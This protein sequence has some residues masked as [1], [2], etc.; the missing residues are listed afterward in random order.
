MSTEIVE[1]IPQRDGGVLLEVPSGE[2]IVRGLAMPHS[3]RRPRGRLWLLESGTGSF[4]FV[5]RAAGR[6]ESVVTLPGFTRGLAFR[7]NLAFVGLLQ[8][9][10][11]ANF[12][13]VPI[14]EHALASGPA[15]SGPDAGIVWHLTLQLIHRLTGNSADLVP[16]R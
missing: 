7:D 10:E 11:S 9:R 6:C 1:P 16:S 8:V 15:A 3:P 5:D 13:E 14:A 12:S 4:G 2:T